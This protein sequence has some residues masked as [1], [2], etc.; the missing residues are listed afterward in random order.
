MNFTK[1]FSVWAHCAVCGEK[2][3]AVMDTNDANVDIGLCVEPC[4]N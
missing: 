4:E 1:S 2:L 3:S